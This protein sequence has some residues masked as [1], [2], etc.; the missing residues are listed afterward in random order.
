MQDPSSLVPDASWHPVYRIA[1]VSALVVA[2]MIVLGIVTFILWPMPLDGTVE[3]WLDLFAR[4]PMR[5]MIAM[6]ATMFVSFL[7]QIP[8]AIAL[9]GAMRRD[10]EGLAALGATL[11]L[12]AIAAYICSSRMFELLA[13]GNE[14]AATT[15]GAR[16]ATLVAAAQSMLT[17]YLG[18][19]ATTESVAGVP[20]QGT[21]FNVSYVLSSLGAFLLSLVMRRSPAFGRTIG[22]VGAI[23]SVASL[24]YFV[25]SVGALL[26]VL[27]L[28][29]LLAW[30]LMLAA[31]LWRVTTRP[32]GT[33]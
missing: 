12:V 20:Y 18:P 30:Y 33:V 7:A 28:P 2:A 13:L 24:A 32:A 9:F 25:P 1:A 23:A 15:D 8:L 4:A 19:Y 21:A 14:Y 16:R 17:T 22:T 26:S 3:T 27:A 29:A 6:D 10:D 31:R 5:G 11:L